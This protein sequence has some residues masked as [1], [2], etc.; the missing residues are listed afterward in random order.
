MC[1]LEDYKPNIAVDD[2]SHCGSSIVTKEVEGLS[3]D[4]GGAK[5]LPFQII[6]GQDSVLSL[7]D[8][9]RY[10][11]DSGRAIFRFFGA[12]N[13]GQLLLEPIH[14]ESKTKRSEGFISDF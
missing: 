7:F 8:L 3:L 4:I 2:L 14:I 5:S 6:S 12:D 9:F 13:I 10:R 11:L 1:S